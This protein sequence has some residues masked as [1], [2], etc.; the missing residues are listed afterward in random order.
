M[1]F[2]PLVTIYV[3]ERL[4]L[5]T[6]TTHLVTNSVQ[7]TFSC[8]LSEKSVFHAFLL[9]RGRRVISLTSQ[10]FPPHGAAGGGYRLAG[11]S[12]ARACQGVPISSRGGGAA[13]L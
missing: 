6:D 11:P 1:V 12:S 8:K 3:L 13:S 10:L 7:V 5:Q 9:S 2:Q 4:G